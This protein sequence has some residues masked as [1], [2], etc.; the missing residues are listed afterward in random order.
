MAAVAASAGLKSRPKASEIC[1]VRPVSSSLAATKSNG[2]SR[3]KRGNGEN[4]NIDVYVHVLGSPTDNKA[5]RTEFLLNGV[6]WTIWPPSSY[7]HPFSNVVH[8][9]KLRDLHKGNLSTLNL[10]FLNGTKTHAGIASTTLNVYSTQIHAVWLNSNT[11]PGGNNPYFNQG[12]SAVHEVGH[13]LGFDTH[14]ATEECFDK[15]PCKT[16]PECIN[17]MSF[18]NDECKTE[19]NSEQIALMRNFATQVKL[20]QRPK[21]YTELESEKA[22]PFDPETSPGD[23]ETSPPEQA[24]NTCDS[25]EDAQ[26]TYHI[27]LDECRK[28]YSQCIS[29]LGEDAK[30]PD[31]IWFC[32]MLKSTP[33]DTTESAATTTSQTKTL[34]VVNK[35]TQPTKSAPPA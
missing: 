33:S 3:Y 27:S 14:T 2:V 8:D 31:A 22:P 16:S 32:I 18:A 13:W 20:G 5:N 4:I 9:E 25:E 30:K 34:A 28:R 17:Y 35:P 1:G 10:Y 21:Y 29:E 7:Y 26:T 6:D 15:H 23:T 19:F 24:S 11:V 12:K